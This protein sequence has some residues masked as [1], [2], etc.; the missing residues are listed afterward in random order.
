MVALA[1]LVATA[2]TAI[3]VALLAADESSP[4]GP[5]FA[6]VPFSAVL[7]AATVSAVALGIV[8]TEAALPRAHRSASGRSAL[9]GCCL[10]VI[11]ATMVA[12]PESGCVA[13]PL[14]VVLVVIA[15]RL[16]PSVRTSASPRK[17]EDDAGS[18]RAGGP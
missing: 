5:G 1:T 16:L 10:L 15:V 13:W 9:F 7:L 8:V 17:S 3:V 12:L 18:E 11:A 6:I 14:A 2:S 4:L